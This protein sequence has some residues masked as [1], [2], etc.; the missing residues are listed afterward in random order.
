MIESRRLLASFVAIVHLCVGSLLAVATPV[1][2]QTADA[3]PPSIEFERVDEGI[4]GDTQVFSANVTD[5]REID[6]VTLYYRLGS[7]EPYQSVA[8]IA[9]AGTS[10]HTATVATEGSDAT[11]VQYY[12]EARDTAGNR[13][14]Q[15]F[16][17]D[18][19]ERQLVQPGQPLATGPVDDAVPAPIK[20]GRSTGRKIFYGVL[21]ALAVG[22]LAAAVSSG[23]GGGGG[24]PAADG[25]DTIPLT[26]TVDPL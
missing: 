22:A 1:S 25:A 14:I 24:S 6:V 26:I 4:A 10:I 7:S 20:P 15:G 3:E 11:V 18:P 16:A 19:I 21:G 13:S 9:L 12:I 17:F 2:A 8:M 23:G 5:D